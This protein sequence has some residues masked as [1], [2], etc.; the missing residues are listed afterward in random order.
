M[1]KFIKTKVASAKTLLQNIDLQILL[2]LLIKFALES[3]KQIFLLFNFGKEKIEM[4]I[5]LQILKGT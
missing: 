4:N 5:M 3:I 1:D 2:H